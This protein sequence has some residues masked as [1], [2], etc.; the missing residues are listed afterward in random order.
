MKKLR[1]K[2]VYYTSASVLLMVVLTG[3]GASATDTF[4]EQFNSGS[5]TE[6]QTLYKRRIKGRTDSEKIIQDYLWTIA[7]DT[8]AE[9]RKDEA[10]LGSVAERKLD[11]ISVYITENTEDLEQVIQEY[12]ALKLSRANYL[13]AQIAFEE[14]KFEKANMLLKQVI[15]T[16]PLYPDVANLKQQVK[17]SWIE[18]IY[19]EVDVSLAQKDFK[20]AITLLKAQAGWIS[21]EQ[22]F[23]DRMA[24]AK[25]LENAEIQ[26]KEE[27]QRL[28]E[29]EKK[30][31]EEEKKAALQHAIDNMRTKKD[32]FTGTTWY[33]DKSTTSYLNKNSFHIYI[34]K[35]K[36][37]K[38]WLRLK[39]QY[40]GDE[41]LI[42]QSYAIN[43][44]GT[45]YTI[46]PGLF[47]V[48]TD[49]DFNKFWEWYDTDVNTDEFEMLNAIANSKKA[50]IRFKGSQY[51]DDR[52]ITSAEKQA[53]KNVLNAYEALNSL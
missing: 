33:Y 24:Q 14:G 31:A 6:C 37:S 20:Q 5:Y 15:E 19:A 26:R 49:F 41:W 40:C 27:A 45:I 46:E 52:E 7:T 48:E 2:L 51:Y 21:Q 34:G 13:E 17:T 39:I 1:K 35:S 32:D 44:D 12:Q 42:I 9:Y 22:G 36:D 38:P 25:A 23:I 30:K 18:Q 4:K 16:D 29:A 43:V 11:A 50:V 53:I 47:D 28:S 8:L 3:C 10:Y